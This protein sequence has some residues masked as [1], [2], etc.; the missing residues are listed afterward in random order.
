MGGHG[1]GAAVGR[2]RPAQARGDRLLRQPAPAAGPAAPAGAA[3]RGHRAFQPRPGSADQLTAATEGAGHG[4]SDGPVH[5]RRRVFRR[6]VR[7]VTG[8]VGVHVPLVRAPEVRDQ[9]GDAAGAAV[10]E[11][12]RTGL[13]H[14]RADGDARAAVRRPAVVRRVCGRGY[15]GGPPWPRSRRSAWSDGRFRAAG[16]AL[17]AS[18][19]WSSPRCSTTSAT[20]IC[21]RALD[22]ATTA[23][24][25]GGTL[26][27]VHWRH[28]VAAY[29]GTGDEVH[30]VI[31]AR[32]ELTL[33]ADHREPDFLAQVYRAVLAGTDPASV[34]GRRRRGPYVTGGE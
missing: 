32:P 19:W 33:T 9:R 20:T 18:T 17:P 7:G 21:A 28:P 11:R 6:P 29:P 4:T 23:L 25:P 8:P 3:A 34:S 14:R 5:P 30:E 31:A 13:L 12:V 10:P 15:G 22:L 2:G 24:S 27:A 26:L 16:L 1:P